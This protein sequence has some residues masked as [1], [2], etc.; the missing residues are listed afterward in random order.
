MRKTCFLTAAGLLAA[1]TVLPAQAQWYGDDGRYDDRHGYDGYGHDSYGYNDGTF[2]CESR[3]RRTTR[4]PTRGYRV[5]LI[6]QFSDMACVRGRT[7]GQ[8]GYGVWVTN[9]CRGL[10]A[11]DNRGNGW[12]NNG[13]GNNG[14]RGND[15][16]RCESRDNRSRTCAMSVGRNNGIRLVRQLSDTPCIEGRN[17]GVSRNGVWVSGGCRAE[18]V[19]SRGRG[20]ERPPGDLGDMRPPGDLGNGYP[21]GGRV[22]RQGNHDVPPPGV[23]RDGEGV[24]GQGARSRGPR[25]V[26]VPRGGQTP[27]PGVIGSAPR[28][29][30][31]PISVAQSNDRPPGRPTSSEPAPGVFRTLP[32][33]QAPAPRQAPTPRGGQEE[34]TRET[35]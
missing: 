7:W 34:R 3:D 12:G 14:Y 1:L 13:W 16:V 35:P 30:P 20:R 17:W 19:V 8:D 33:E 18:F 4:C 5:Q 27:P 28:P 23:L 6:R 31:A 21:P 9:G 10:F 2:R 11:F 15:F 26:E 25:V 32:A 24:N 29:R 22:Q